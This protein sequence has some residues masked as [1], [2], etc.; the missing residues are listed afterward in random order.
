MKNLGIG[1][2]CWDQSFTAHT[3]TPDAKLCE[4]LFMPWTL[5]ADGD[6]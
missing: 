5:D 4:F 6:H 3:I 1:P 2:K